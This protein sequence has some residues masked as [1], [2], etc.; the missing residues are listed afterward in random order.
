M[1]RKGRVVR[2]DGGRE[3]RKG[4]GRDGKGGEKGKKLR[5]M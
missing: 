1:E 4:E 2:G 3:A 5:N